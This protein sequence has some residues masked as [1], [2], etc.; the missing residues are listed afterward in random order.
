M[1]QTKTFA[2]NYFKGWKSNENV[3]ITYIVCWW[4]LVNINVI[5]LENTKCVATAFAFLLK[6]RFKM[7]ICYLKYLLVL[8]SVIVLNLNISCVHSKLSLLFLLSILC[9]SAS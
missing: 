6:I 8:V 3:L 9:M 5:C 2:D 7:F 1:L 4:F